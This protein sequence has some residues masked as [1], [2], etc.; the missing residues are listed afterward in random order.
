[1]NK[2]PLHFQIIIALI[3]GVILGMSAIAFNFSELILDWL[4]PFGDI[5]M[6]LLKLISV[7]LILVSLIK[8]IADL[9][10]IRKLSQMGLKTFSIYFLTTAFAI[11]LGLVLVNIIKPGKGMSEDVKRHI[12]QEFSVEQSEVTTK[13]IQETNQSPLTFLV[14]MIPDNITASAS[15]NKNMLQI[16]FFA[17]FVGI[18]LV[19]LPESKTQNINKLLS[20]LNE[21]ILKL[22]DLIMKFSP[23][24]VLGLMS[25]VIVELA[26]QNIANTI[27]IL[28]ALTW[29][30]FTVLLGLFTI[31]LLV[32]PLLARFFGNISFRTFYKG[33]LPAQLVGFSTSSS[34]ATL[35][36][37]IEC[38]EQNLNV[39]KEVSSF[40]LPLGATINMD[41]TALYQGVA[42]VF[43]AQV[44]GIDLCIFQQ[45]NLILLTTLASIGSAAVPGAGIVMLIVVLES[46][47]IPAAGIAL[48]LAPDRLL[49]MFRTVT[50]LTGDLMVSTIIEKGYKRIKN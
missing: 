35:P 34:A 25:S 37:T 16:I 19:L 3:A 39:R 36:V 17:I 6:K 15:S 13:S 12:T 27:D 11:S 31:L 50:N 32:Y 40:V 2:I 28:S 10:D 30:T 45:L 48:I 21:L 42:A 8:G 23:I 29:Y 7:P 9:K 20:E 24:G 5:F 4:K 41:G 33:I 1:M 44:L 14:E 49:D 46:L 18:G 38:A 43:I 26:G 22:I 47:G